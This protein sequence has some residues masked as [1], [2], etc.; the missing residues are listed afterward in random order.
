[1][2]SEHEVGGSHGKKLSMEQETP[3]V[4]G[5]EAQTGSWASHF[6]LGARAHGQSN[7]D[8]EKTSQRHVRPQ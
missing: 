6:L 3:A 1:M 2:V 8:H 5:T 7:D 4:V